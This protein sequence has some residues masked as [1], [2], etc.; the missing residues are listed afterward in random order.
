[1]T[2]QFH[3]GATRTVD[4][5][6]GDKVIDVPESETA[7]TLELVRLLTSESPL[8]ES[9]IMPSCKVAQRLGIW[10]IVCNEIV[11][12]LL[13][14]QDDQTIRACILEGVQ[15]HRA[16]FIFYE[17]DAG[18]RRV[19]L[20]LNNRMPTP[21][22]DDEETSMDEW[23]GLHHIKLF[24]LSGT[25]NLEIKVSPEAYVGEADSFLVADRKDDDKDDDEPAEA[26]LSPSRG[27]KWKVV[28]Q[29]VDD[30]GH[31]ELPAW[32]SIRK[33]MGLDY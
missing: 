28:Q 14:S 29:D 7:A 25:M 13:A 17:D 5:V 4:R 11:K 30:E 1:M 33:L 27:R 26:Y 15:M 23:H 9:S 3:D 21:P 20:V 10:D 16:V 18:C 8:I 19:S 32:S 24:F 31:L 2:F 22:T 6:L 12:R